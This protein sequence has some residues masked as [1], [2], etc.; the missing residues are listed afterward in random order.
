[1]KT[2][3]TKIILSALAFACALVAVT[4]LFSVQPAQAG[5]T[6][7]LQEVGSNVVATGSGAIDLTG[8]TFVVFRLYP[9][10]NPHEATIVTGLPDSFVDLYDSGASGPT[11]FGSS[12]VG[13]SAS[14]GS[15]DKVGIVG[16]HTLAVPT[17]YVSGSALSDR[18]T[19]SDTT[20]A[21]LGVT[22]GTYVWTWGTGA[23]QNFTFKSQRRRQGP[24]SPSPIPQP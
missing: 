11:S 16:G 20:V 24:R 9:A 3:L 6:V 8:L 15:G 18:A 7:T 5:Y 14:S 12:P 4:S 23:N 19:Y 13:T 22:P 17:G 21:S 2:K 1:M 10:I